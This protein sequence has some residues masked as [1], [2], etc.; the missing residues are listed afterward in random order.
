MKMIKNIDGVKSF[1]LRLR[2]TFRQ[3][4]LSF[5]LADRDPFKELDMLHIFVE[6]LRDDMQVI[7]HDIRSLR[8]IAAS[9]QSTLDT[10]VKVDLEFGKNIQSLIDGFSSIA[11]TLQS[12]NSAIGQISFSMQMQQTIA[13]AQRSASANGIDLKVYSAKKP[14]GSEKPD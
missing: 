8:D 11:D 13:E 4:L 2:R 6:N 5:L 3:R 12:H 9:M 1:V 10:S 7:D 14:S